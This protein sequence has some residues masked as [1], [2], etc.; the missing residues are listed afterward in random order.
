MYRREKLIKPL[1]DDII[2]SKLRPDQEIEMEKTCEKGISK[3]HAKWSPV[4]KFLL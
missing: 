1:F 4:S 3:S 2:I